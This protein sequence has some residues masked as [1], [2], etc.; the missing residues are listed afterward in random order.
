MLN[1][2]VSFIM[3]NV[4]EVLPH[5]IQSWRGDI[6]VTSSLAAHFPTPWAAVVGGPIAKRHNVCGGCLRGGVRTGLDHAV[7]Y[8]E[9]GAWIDGKAIE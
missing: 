1:L 4:H 5:M 6:I 3:K 9:F 2:N 8:E 7:S